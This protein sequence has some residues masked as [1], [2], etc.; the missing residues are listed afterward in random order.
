MSNIGNELAEDSLYKELSS[1]DALNTL[2]FNIGN[3]LNIYDLSN[4]RR[5]KLLNEGFGRFRIYT[6]NDNIIKLQ[7]KYYNSF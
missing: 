2:G 4:D 7:F 6:Y 1:Y 3:P 5:N